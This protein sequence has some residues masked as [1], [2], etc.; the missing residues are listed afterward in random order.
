MSSFFSCLLKKLLFKIA[1]CSFSIYYFDYEESNYLY[2]I[3]FI[4]RYFC[5]FWLIF[6]KSKETYSY[7][8]KLRMGGPF[9]KF[10]TR[11]L[12]WRQLEWPVITPKNAIPNL[13]WPDIIQKI[14][15]NAIPNVVQW[16]KCRTYSG[17]PAFFQVESW[18]ATLAH[19]LSFFSR[20]PH[21]KDWL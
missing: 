13:E 9:P 1:E 3:F 20:F 17:N 8:L 6:L 18:Y 10:L 14:S 11:D 2:C 7:R 4:F 19:F 5:Q 16:K 21:R 12:E 15:K